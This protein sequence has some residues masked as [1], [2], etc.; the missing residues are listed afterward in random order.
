M[1][2]AEAVIIYHKSSTKRHL[3]CEGCRK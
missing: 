3:D 2:L 1:K